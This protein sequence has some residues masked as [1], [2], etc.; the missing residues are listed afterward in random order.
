MPGSPYFNIAKQMADWLSIVSE[1]KINSST[2]EIADQLADIVLED[3]KELVSFDVVSLYT[4]VPVNEAIVV[5]ANLLYDGTL[6]KPPVDK[7]TF[8]KLLNVCSKNVIMS[9]NDGL[10]RQIDGLAMGSPPAPMLANAWMSTFDTTVSNNAT[11]YTRYMD[12]I[13]RDINKNDIDQKLEELNSLHP[14]QSFTVE[15]ETNGTIPFLDMKIT[16][17]E[18]RIESSWY[19]KDT[20]TGLLMNFHALAP[21]KY[22]KPVVIGMIHRIFRACSTYKT[23]HEGLERAKMILN[24][25]QYP[26]QLVDSIVRDTLN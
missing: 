6:K 10:F 3:D 25:N 18:K 7:D 16:H 22:K 9:S 20:D 24:R 12:D 5:C 14:L 8:T 15:R 2:K 21:L 26:E 17:I 4:N 19:T 11:L 13:L 23:F 1:C